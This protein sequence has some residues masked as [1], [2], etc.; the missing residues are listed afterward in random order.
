MF[1]H[2]LWDARHQLDVGFGLSRERGRGGQ[3][4][5]R[6]WTDEHNGQAERRVLY[7]DS[8]DVEVSFERIELGYETRQQEMDE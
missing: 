4:R 5:R 2:M 6:V 7:L 3:M 1:S 8:E